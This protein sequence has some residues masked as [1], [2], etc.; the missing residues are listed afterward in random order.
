MDKN[1]SNQS[2]RP[3]V[4]LRKG[5]LKICNKFTGENP[6]PKGEKFAAYFQNT[7]S[8]E[9]LWNAASLARTCSVIIL[10]ITSFD[11]KLA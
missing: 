6:I 4:F 11:I 1:G 9:H 10:I 7:L 3:E 5:V 8:K 2:S